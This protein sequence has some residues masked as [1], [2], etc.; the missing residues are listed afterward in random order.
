MKKWRNTARAFRAYCSYHPGYFPLYTLKLLCSEIG[1]AYFNLW[2]SAEIITKLVQGD[3]LSGITT[4]IIVALCGNLLLG[5]LNALFS[6]ETD[7]AKDKLEAREKLCFEQKILSLDYAQLE[8]PK[9]QELR[10]KI[11]TDSWIN[12]HGTLRMRISIEKQ[13]SCILN[14]LVGIA[15]LVEMVSQIR[16]IGLNWV[17]FAL[18]TGLIATTV[19]LVLWTKT[20]VRFR[21]SAAG[22]ISDALIDYNRVALTES[23]HGAD[24]RLYRLSPYFC[25]KRESAARKVRAAQFQYMGKKTKT[26]IPKTF[27]LCLSTALSYMFACLYAVRGA[28]PIGGIIKYVGYIESL[29]KNIRGMIELWP[30]LEEN[31]P[32][33]DQYMS[34]LDM[35]S[36]SPQGI[37]FPEQT[38]DIEFQNVS[39]RYPGSEDYA[40]NSISLRLHRGTKLAIVGENGS[41]KSTFIKLLCRFYEPESGEIRLGGTKIQEFEYEKYLRLFSVVFQDF[42]LLSF[43]I[44][45]NIA[46]ESEYSN[47]DVYAA[48]EKAGL[49]ERLK[50]LPLGISTPLNK[51][52]DTEGVRLSGGEAQKVA[53]ARALYRDAPFLILDEPTAALDPLAEEE[54]YNSI[55]KIARNK[56]SIFISHRLSSCRF[57]DRIAVFDAGRIVQMG[58]HEQLLND[59]NGKYAQLWNAQAQYY[60]KS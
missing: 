43:P 14:L 24:N 10:N 25:Q 3:C 59:P 46:G 28:F 9:I 53:L 39:F 7:S 33:L 20:V 37:R 4:A 26:D 2:I 38:D 41:G 58:S 35:P 1:P 51:D 17:A 40:L 42:K 60:S 49:A 44:G 31:R 18:L 52:V 15:L 23:N 19:G 6:R 54:V 57:A 30:E 12:L 36:A 5:V 50:T 27:L 48:L 34:F 55:Q 13:I 47:E 32:Y 21:E 45:E 22:A 8:D 56:T 11:E 29:T 16:T